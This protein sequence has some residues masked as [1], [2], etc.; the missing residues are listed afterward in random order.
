M[1][2]FADPALFPSFH[3][4]PSSSAAA[5]AAAA[6]AD[7]FLLAQIKEDMT[8]TKPT[9]IVRDRSGAD[10]AV[11]FEDGD[12]R[13]LGQGGI[14]FRKGHTLVVPRATRTDRGEGKQ[15]IV[16]VPP[17]EGASVRIL[18]AGLDQVFELGA[19]L[20]GIE[21]AGKGRKCAAC[22]KEEEKEEKD[23]EEL[24]NPLMR[25]TG[26][27]VVAYCSKACQVRGWSE[28]GHK[29]NCKVIR[30]IKEIWP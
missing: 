15:P 16:R 29:T 18:P 22:G 27:G 5:A 6:T 19:V 20:D 4:L 23:G 2:I 7:Q 24:K 14:R 30:S 8:I 26:C 21:G 3:E 10:F 9:V 17:G 13:G 11:T 1:P 12:H 28:L 25:C